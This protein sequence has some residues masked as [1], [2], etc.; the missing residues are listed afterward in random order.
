MSKREDEM[1]KKWG[2]KKI[3]TFCLFRDLLTWSTVDD[4]ADYFKDLKGNEIKL[5]KNARVLHW[6]YKLKDKNKFIGYRKA[7]TSTLISEFWKLGI[8]THPWK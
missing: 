4:E 8:T 5:F 2:K 6:S 7:D 3:D 1:W